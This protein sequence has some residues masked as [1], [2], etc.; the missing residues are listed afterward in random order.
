MWTTGAPSPEIAVLT[1]ECSWSM[2]RCSTGTG[3]SQTS[4]RTGTALETPSPHTSRCTGPQSWT[5]LGTQTAMWTQKSCQR[6]ECLSEGFRTHPTVQAQGKNTEYTRRLRNTG[7][8]LARFSG[9]YLRCRRLKQHRR[10]VE[11]GIGRANGVQLRQ[12]QQRPRMDINVRR[13][14]TSTSVRTCVEKV[15]RI[16]VCSVSC[17]VC[18]VPAKHR[19]R[20]CQPEESSC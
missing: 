11:F 10:I 12:Q 19:E 1:Q 4:C 20:R 6:A 14:H 2:S 17:V 13:T 3:P 9:A 18:I 5:R 15:T 16:R 8:M 7:W